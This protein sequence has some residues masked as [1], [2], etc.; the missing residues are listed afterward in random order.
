MSHTP[1]KNPV[2]RCAAFARVLLT[3]TAAVVLAGAYVVAV[4]PDREEAASAAT[5]GDPVIGAAGD[6][7]CPP[8]SGSTSLSRCQQARTGDALSSANPSVVLPL[9]DT[10]YTNA[11]LGEYAGS[12]DLVKWGT[13][14]GAGYQSVSRPVPGNHE[15][16]TAGAAGYFGYFGG[17]AGD[18]SKG[19]YSFDV[20]GPNN[21]F[22]WHLIALNSECANVGGC[23]AGSPQETWL[24]NDLAANPNV[25][26]LAYWHRPR[27]SSS[28][29]TPS[30]TAYAPFWND[31]YNAK[32][33]VVLNGHAHDYERFAP[34]T[35]SGASDP[36]N[37]VR[38]FI[39]GTGGD[40]FQTMGSGIANSE[41]RN[42]D[43]F[44][45]LKMTLHNGSYDWQF[46]P[47]AGYSF[48]DSGSSNCHTTSSK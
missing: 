13:N 14:G 27:F 40:D 7:A 31:L 36:A 37:G 19:Y 29:S 1:S 32:A 4:G 48:T 33:D 39:V 21:A 41:I 28:A 38:E 8:G 20:N 44:G 43:S 42:N 46:I 10:Q 23:G 9:G 30:S 17:N 22:R 45:V 24:K 12:Y 3:A 26:T 47:A 5:A 18:P 16:G 2:A 11:T 6:I 35:S 25:C 34:Q 15:Y